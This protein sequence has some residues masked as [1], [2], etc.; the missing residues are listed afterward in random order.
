MP[1]RDRP[2]IDTIPPARTIRTEIAEIH[3]QLDLLRRLLRLPVSVDEP[4][5]EQPDKGGQH[6]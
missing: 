4:R 5:R 6:A 3:R 1:L 2:L